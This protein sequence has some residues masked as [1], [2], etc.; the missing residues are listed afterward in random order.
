MT[1]LKHLANEVMRRMEYQKTPTL[2]TIE[3]YVHM[4]LNAI[5]DLFILTGRASAFDDNKIDYLEFTY[6]ADFGID[7]IEFILLTTQIGFLEKVQ[8]G[9]NVQVSYTT[10]ALSITKADMPYKNLSGSIA[11]FKNR[12]RIIYYKMTSYV[13]E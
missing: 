4:V 8:A 5:K 11:E 1:D 3:E 7:E 12:R 2:I 13:M 10:D 9:V 6:D